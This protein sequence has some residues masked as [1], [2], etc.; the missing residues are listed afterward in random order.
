[1]SHNR[2]THYDGLYGESNTRPATDYIF[3]ESLETRSPTFDWIVKP[4]IHTR[5]YQLFFL[6]TGKVVFQDTN[7]SCDLDSPCLLC[8]PPSALHGLVYTPDTTGHILTIADSLIDAIFPSSSPALLTL[9]RLHRIEKQEDEQAF[10]EALTLFQK[11]DQ[12]IFGDEPE[13]QPMIRAYLAQLWIR[14]YR[15][16]KNR[17]DVITTGQS[18]ALAHFRHFQKLIKEARFPKSIPDFADDLNI[19]A[20]HLNRI[21]QSVVGKSALDLIQEHQ[22]DEAKKYLRF[23]SY[24]ISEIA[25]LLN[26]EYPNYFAK[27]FR[28]ITGMSPKEFRESQ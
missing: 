4:H 18:P 25:F 13:R 22:I 28:K 11:I 10:H 19:S 2:I 26:F 5:L 23:T 3:S 16:I 27:L 1:M 14:L 12:E 20:V 6:K 8:I 15:L 9:S 21:C 24:S 7:G 17:N